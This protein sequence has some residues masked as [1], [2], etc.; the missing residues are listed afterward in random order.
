MFYDKIKNKNQSSRD[1]FENCVQI[2]YELFTLEKKF[3]H[4][5]LDTIIDI[6]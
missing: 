2:Y 1:I 4:S 3:I 5:L 6:R